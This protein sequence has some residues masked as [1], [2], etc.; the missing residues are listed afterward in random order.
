MKFLTALLLVLFC[1]VSFLQAQQHEVPNLLGKQVSAKGGW[2]NWCPSDYAKAGAKVVFQ[3]N[4]IVLTPADTT[5]VDIASPTNQQIIK[6]LELEAG[7]AYQLSFATDSD[8]EGNF[9]VNY[10]LSKPPYSSYASKTV[11]LK[12]QKQKHVIKFTPKPV[13]DV[14]DT[15]RS[16]RFFCGLLNGGQVTISDLV[17]VE[18]SH[19]IEE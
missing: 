8:A 10:I 1:S 14:Y 4:T 6:K 15:P 2:G 18:V 19:E 17:L 3:D 5:Q 7:K 9:T 13:K 11:K 12:A 16:L